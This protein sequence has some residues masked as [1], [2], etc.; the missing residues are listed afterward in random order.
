MNFNFK[1]VAPHELLPFIMVL[2]SLSDNVFLVGGAVR[3]I[4][5]DKNPN[6]FDFVTDVPMDRLIEE[7]EA[8]GFTV[9]QTGVAHMVLNVGFRDTIVE[10]SNFR[11]DKAC[12]GRHAEVELGTIDDDA[13]R[14]DFTINALFLNTKTGEIVDPTGTG[15]ADLKA[16]VLRF[17]GR[18]KDRIKEDFLRVF[19]FYRFVNKGFTPD[20]KSLKACREMFTEAHNRVAPERV[21]VELEKMAGIC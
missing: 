2:E 8:G 18:P 17:V 13:H 1:A 7:F 14:R 20:P 6:D 16:K 3:D 5:L 11:K 19:R 4:L 10:I 12:D 15:V 9:S 21:R